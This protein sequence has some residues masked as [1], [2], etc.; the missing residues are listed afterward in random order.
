M[1]TK[2]NAKVVVLG[3]GFGGLETALSLRMRLPHHADIVLVSDKDYFIFKPNTIY[4]PFGLDPNKLKFGLARPT[5]HKDIK[6]VQARATQIDPISKHVTLE[7][8]AHS[9]D[10]AY[11]YLVVATGAG[12]RSGAVPGLGDFA[13]AISTP[14]EMLTLRPRFQ[15]IAAQSRDGI[16]QQ[17]H[18]LVPP[19]NKHPGPLYEMVLMLDTW[20][21]RKKV[22]AN[23]TLAFSTHEA[24]YVQSYGPKMHDVVSEEFRQRG[25]SG[26]TRYAVDSVEEK[27][28]LF[29]N[30]EQASFDLLVTFPPYAASTLFKTLPVDPRGFISTD[31]KSTRVVGH[32]EIFAVGDTADFPIKQ[33]Q[34]AVRQA[35]VAAEHLRAQIL[36]GVPQIEFESTSM[37]VMEGLDRATFVQAPLQVTGNYDK[38]VEVPLG[39]G[40]SYRVGS[41]P[42]WRLGKM[43]VGAYLPWRF[44]AGNPFHSGAPWKGME[45]GTKIMS[46]ILS[47]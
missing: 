13:N 20:L 18:F 24:T 17:V 2:A 8:Y 36:G 16:K 14:E 7:S 42:L 31:M 12:M 3:G 43:A 30:Q 21:R 37:Y 32:P 10:L 29:R 45:A 19:N 44:K 39:A 40:G 6:F 25:I 41:S 38:P 23:V 33:A 15:Q 26:Y 1:S 5:R 27:R 11:D 4:I 47:R 35:D 28:L 46:G 34:V 9:Y 22:R